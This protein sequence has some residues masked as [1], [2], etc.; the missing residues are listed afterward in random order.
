[1]LRKYF[2]GWRAGLARCTAAAAFVAILNIIFLGVA[3][4]RLK[5]FDRKMV[6]GER[7]KGDGALFDG[8]CGKA[9]QL[10]I[11]LHLIINILSTVL[12][13]AGNFAQQVLTA[14]TRRE[15]DSAHLG[16]KWLDIGVLSI[17]NLRKI[18]RSRVIAWSILAITS[19]PIHL[20]YNSIISLETGVN[21][22]N[23][24]LVAENNLTNSK[25]EVAEGQSLD[26]FVRLDNYDCIT[27]YAQNFISDR[28]DVILVVESNASTSLQNNS[29]LRKPDETEYNRSPYGW[30]CVS[31]IDQFSDL[32]CDASAVASNADEWRVRDPET[33][34]AWVPEADRKS[35]RV[36]YCL[37]KPTEESCRL[38]MSIPLL[39]TVV[40]CNILKL[41]GLVMTWLCLNNRPLLT[42]GDAIA[43]FLDRPDPTTVDCRM[44]SHDSGKPLSWEPGTRPWLPK[45]RRWAS[46]VSRRRYAITIS[47]CTIALLITFIFLGQG[48]AHIGGSPSL[49]NLWNRGFGSLDFACLISYNN[50]GSY[51]SPAISVALISNLPQLI[52]SLL[53]TA[54][55][56]MWTA[57][58]V[59]SEWNGYGIHRKGLRTTS[60]VGKQR[61]SYWLSLPLS[62]F[63]VRL[64]VNEHGKIREMI[65]TSGYSPIAIIFS[66]LCG[67]SIIMVTVGLSLRRFK[68]A[69]PQVGTCSAVVGAACHRPEGDDDA[70]LKQVQWGV[71][72]GKDGDDYCCITSWEVKEPQAGKSY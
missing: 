30:I 3:A 12:L 59:G 51:S 10:S 48:I 45:M 34:G 52:V 11:W 54:V 60:P 68:T 32:S 24:W 35:L 55:N 20:F 57:M 62:I 7:A 17:H 4:P 14:P 65:T 67:F 71:V 18:S 46:S 58:L 26:D 61:G 50:D 47:L 72:S 64:L 36:K 42:L 15:I 40:G 56:G 21:R 8:D 9:K 25:N 53:Y 49:A 63:F 22:Y 38:T 33:E 6:T 1:M 43:S 27:S 31:L 39:A 2:T 13:T 37:S 16:H 19:V 29:Q 28:S 44:L 5:P 66:I 23:V 41:L 70:A 69:I